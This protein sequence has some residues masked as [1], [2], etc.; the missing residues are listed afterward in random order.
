V[1]TALGGMLVQHSPTQRRAALS[2]PILAGPYRLLLT[3]TDIIPG[4]VP[5]ALTYLL[6]RRRASTHP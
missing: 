6:L 2:L 1:I 3:F 4:T 5:I